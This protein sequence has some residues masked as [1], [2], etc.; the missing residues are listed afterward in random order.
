MSELYTTPMDLISAGIEPKLDRGTVPYL[1]QTRAGTMVT[2]ERRVTG[3]GRWQRRRTIR[4]LQ[5]VLAGLGDPF[6][7]AREDGSC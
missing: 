7:A 5:A 6:G 2:L 4:Q 3:L 1:V